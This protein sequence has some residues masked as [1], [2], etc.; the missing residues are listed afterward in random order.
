MWYN[1]SHWTEYADSSLHCPVLRQFKK[2]W[3]STRILESFHASLVSCMVRLIWS[4]QQRNSWVAIW[5]L[6][7]AAHTL[8][9]LP[10]VFCIS[11][12]VISN[13]TQE[14]QSLQS[15][16]LSVS[17]SW[18][19]HMLTDLTSC[20]SRVCHL[21][22]GAGLYQKRDQSWDY[23]KFCLRPKVQYCLNSETITCISA[24]LDSAQRMDSLLRGEV[25]DAKLLKSSCF[26]IFWIAR[27]KWINGSQGGGNSCKRKTVGT[28]LL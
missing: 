2:T 16:Q 20:S 4:I 5:P 10:W 23:S 27:F 21:P 28:Q 7:I 19:V 17:A 12:S 24:V 1:M 9:T 26:F 13:T 15:H 14:W 22:V 18:H 3:Q 25:G 6:P 11:P 8:C